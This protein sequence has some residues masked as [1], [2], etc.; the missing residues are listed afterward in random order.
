MNAYY[1]F[2]AI[3]IYKA[4]R[5]EL[6]NVFSFEQGV[7]IK[8]MQN[9]II[10][11]FIFIV[12][13]YTSQAD[14]LKIEF[15]IPLTLFMI[16]YLVF[17]GVKGSIQKKVYFKDQ[18]KVIKIKETN[19]V[20]KRDIEESKTNE[21]KTKI[22]TQMN[23][24]ELFLDHNLTIHSFSKALNSNSKIVSSILNSEFNQN[25]VSFI[26]SYRIAEAKKILGKDQYRNYT[27]EAISEMVGFNSKSAFNRAFKQYTNQT[28][29]EFRKA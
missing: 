13:I 6:K 26:N 1:I 4:H 5:K 15:Q 16:M 12:C 25:F 20:S 19:T 3:I 8:W 24:E 21:L 10:G 23:E 28:P 7:S 17:I 2:K 29:S 27:V 11:Y 14:N 18:N 9:Y 22:M